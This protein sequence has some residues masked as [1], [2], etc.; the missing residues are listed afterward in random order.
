MAK[1]LDRGWRRFLK[2][3]HRRYVEKF[4][5]DEVRKIKGKVL[6]VG[7]GYADYRSLCENACEVIQTDIID[8]PGIDLIEDVHSLTFEDGSFDAVIA[9]ELFEHLAEPKRAAAEIF[10]VLRVDGD[11]LVTVPFMFRV[12]GDPDDYNRFTAS[13]IRKLF[14]DFKLA[15]IQNFGNRI[16]VVS[17]IFSTAWKPLVAARIINFGLFFA[18]KNCQSNDCPSGFGCVFKK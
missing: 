3:M 12:H 4:V 18:L 9:V 16:S 8:G 5:L 6:I 10:R 14:K 15:S 17:D 1:Y 13:G 11:F 2:T 7:A